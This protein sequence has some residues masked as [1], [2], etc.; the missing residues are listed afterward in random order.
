MSTVFDWGRTFHD[1]SGR[2][3]S[4]ATATFYIAGSVV[5]KIAIYPTAAD[6]AAGT[7]ALANPQTLNSAGRLPQQ[8]HSAGPCRVVIVSSTGATLYDEDNVVTLTGATIGTLLY[9][10]TAAEIAAGITPTDYT[11]PEGDVRRYGATGDGS[12]NDSTAIQAAFTCSAVV[13]FDKAKSYNISSTTISLKKHNQIVHGNGSTLVYSGSTYAVDFTPISNVYL[14]GNVIN[15][16]FVTCSAASATGYRLRC[17][18]ALFN[19]CSSGVTGNN[20]VAYLLETDITYGTGPY[21]NLF[22]GC[23]AGGNGAATGQF[24]WKAALDAGTPTRGPNANQWVGGRTGSMN[25]AFLIAGSG[26]SFFGVTVEATKS[27]GYVFDFTNANIVSIG[28]GSFNNVVTSCYVE[29]NSG[30]NFVRF[31]AY[32]SQ[33]RVVF[34]YVTS[35]GAGTYLTDSSLNITNQIIDEKGYSFANS[36]STAYNTLDYYDENANQGTSNSWTPVIAGSSTAGTQ[37]YSIQNGRYTRIGNLVFIKCTVLLSAKDAATAGNL[38]ITGL[39]FTSKNVANSYASLTISGA[40]VLHS[41]AYTYCG[42]RI[43]PNTTYISLMENGTNLAPAL[44]GAAALKAATEFEISGS[45]E[46]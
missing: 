6:Q 37:T 40:N 2:L 17:S 20:G 15:E 33:C 5:T 44:L 28:S 45:Y 38:R 21:Y 24:G 18:Y 25:T 42:A 22:N 14:I 39:P 3:A 36:G 26:N 27:G 30:A 12:T 41:G 1:N 29:G 34:P 13:T 7:N 35:L 11:Y 16:L 8:V 31:G 19:N 46:V 23:I 4:S 32:T 43:D 9:P 10:R